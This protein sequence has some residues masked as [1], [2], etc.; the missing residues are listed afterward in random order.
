MIV[1]DVK[2]KI[3]NPCKKE[4]TEQRGDNNLKH[5]I[6]LTRCIKIGSYKDILGLRFQSL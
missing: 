6:Q 5:S 1:P 2:D 3:S 4:D